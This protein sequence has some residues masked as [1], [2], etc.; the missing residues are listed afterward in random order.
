MNGVLKAVAL[1]SMLFVGPGVDRQEP[2][3]YLCIPDL[4]TGFIKKDGR[5][6]RTN[7]RPSN[8]RMQL[9]GARFA[10]AAAAP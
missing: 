8:Q 4:S 3:S 6:E 1:V 5:W 9:T 7:F 10:L 2:T